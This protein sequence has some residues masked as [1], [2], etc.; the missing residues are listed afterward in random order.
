MLWLSKCCLPASLGLRREQGLGS[1]VSLTETA[2]LF[3]RC[4]R[5]L[6]CYRMLSH[7][8][9]V[10]FF[11]I[12]FRSFSCWI[13]EYLE[14]SQQLS[15]LFSF[16]RTDVSVIA[17]CAAWEG[18]W[19]CATTTIA[20][21]RVCVFPPGMNWC[22]AAVVSDAEAL[23]DRRCIGTRMSLSAVEYN[24]PFLLFYEWFSCRKA[25]KCENH[26]IVCWAID[27]VQVAADEAQCFFQSGLLTLNSTQKNTRIFNPNTL[28]F[29]FEESRIK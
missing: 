3:I 1:G 29:S 16:R 26:T 13:P 8:D 11:Q 27:A 28:H 19:L 14:H 23:S 9:R 5:H 10:V 15:W 2:P 12:I 20:E 6:P 17:L 22:C 24:F 7:E 21:G 4:L 25:L 18:M